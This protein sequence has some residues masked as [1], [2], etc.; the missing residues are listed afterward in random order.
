MDEPTDT[1]LIFGDD[2]YLVEE[3][4]HR[5]IGVIR[6]R[7][8]GELAVESVD[9]KAEGIGG[10]AEE[11]ASPSLFA[12]HKVTVLKRFSLTSAGKTA[13]Q[14]E[15]YAGARLPEGQYLVMMPEKVDKRLRLVKAVTGRGGLIEC[16]HLSG[17]ALAAWILKRFAEEGKH[18]SPAVA[19]GLIDLKGEDLRAIDSE[20]LKAVTY[21]GESERITK[22][23]IEL[24]VGRSRTERIF[25]LVTHVI[26]RQPAA[27]LETLGDL[28]DANESA[29]GM[30]FLLTQE[31]RRLVLIRL[32][33]LEENGRLDKDMGFARFKSQ[34][35][36]LYEAWTEANCFPRREASLNRKPYFLYMRFRECAGF[37]LGGLMDLME[38]LCKANTLLV[39]TS[40]SPKVVLERV[41]AGMVSP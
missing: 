34:V 28:L 39:S 36:P 25:E 41:I 1:Y 6:A 22:K 32:F 9:Y 26:M 3:A 20:I 19:E 35:L 38:R 2:E 7:H 29:I 11:M 21:A 13:E 4:L 18:A 15:K 30:V 16:N 31:V 24:L 12:Q 14:L 10:L 5:V 40:E 27:A 8:G 33:L 37:A 23:D 17:E